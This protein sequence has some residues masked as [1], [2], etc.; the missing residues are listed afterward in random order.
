MPA[1]R[2]PSASRSRRVTSL[3]E[4]DVILSLDAAFLSAGYP[5]T[6][7]YTRDF[8]SRRRPD[9]KI[10]PFA[11][12]DEQLV[13]E[14]RPMNRFYM[15][16]SLADQ[17]RREGRSP[18]AAEHRANSSTTRASSPP[19]SASMPAAARRATPITR[20]GS[21]ALVKELQAHRARRGDCR[22][23]QA[24]PVVHALAHAMNEVLGNAGKT[25]FYTDPVQLN[26]GDQ[27]GGLKELVADMQRGQG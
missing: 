1:R 27:L 19:G 13:N 2:W 18:P 17:H 12:G 23:E 15:L 5:G 24:S 8:A 26:P 4:A 14:A 6:Q 16:E 7:L 22:D 3:L 21:D 9:P 25:V 10:R 20:S 11:T